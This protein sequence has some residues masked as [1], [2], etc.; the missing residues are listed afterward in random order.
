MEADA[1]C[2]PESLSMQELIPED[3]ECLPASHE[4]QT[5]MLDVAANLPAT[6]SAHSLWLLSEV[7]LP[8][9]QAMHCDWSAD[10]YLPASHAAQEVEPAA[11]KNPLGQDVQ[12]SCEALGWEPAGQ[13]KHEGA[14][15]IL[16]NLPLGQ[17][18]HVSESASLY[19]P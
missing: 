17:L 18:E 8:L 2:F 4:L 10:E 15:S 5:V 19:F 3:G 16:A 1:V 7:T 14:P 6:H 12:L 9:A 11:A 13:S